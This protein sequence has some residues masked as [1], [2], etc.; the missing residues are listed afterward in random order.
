MGQRKQFTFPIFVRRY[1]SP[2][3][4]ERS[5]IS[6]RSTSPLECIGMVQVSRWRGG[7]F[8]LAESLLRVHIFLLILRPLNKKLHMAHPLVPNDRYP[9][10]DRTG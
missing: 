10:P 4:D 7:K 1:R 2:G 3:G 8:S 6:I 5:S 9:L